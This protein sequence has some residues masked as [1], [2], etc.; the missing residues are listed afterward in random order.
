M[1]IILKIAV[2]YALASLPFAWQLHFRRGLAVPDALLWGLRAPYDVLAQLSHGAP[3][4][5]MLVPLGI[6]L[7][8]MFIG[9]TIAWISESGRGS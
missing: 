9:L 3:V 6:F 1:R 7:F 5:L 8:V 2:V 4:G